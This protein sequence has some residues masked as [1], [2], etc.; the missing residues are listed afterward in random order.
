MPPYSSPR[1]MRREALPRTKRNSRSFGQSAR[2][3]RIPNPGALAKQC[4]RH[5]QVVAQVTTSEALGFL[6]QRATHSAPTAA[7]S[8]AR[9]SPSPLPSAPRRRSRGTRPRA[10]VRE[11][12][13][14]SP[15]CFG[16]PKPDVDQVGAAGDHLVETGQDLRVVL[17]AE[18]RGESAGDDEAGIDAPQERRP[19][20]GSV[21]GPPPITKSERPSRAATASNSTSPAPVSALERLSRRAWRPTP[22]ACR[23]RQPGRSP[24]SRLGSRSRPACEVDV[25][26]GG[27]DE[28]PWPVFQPLR[29]PLDNVVQCHC[30]ER[31]DARF[32][33][34]PRS[35][36]I[37]SCTEW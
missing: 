29:D 33:S 32:G 30:V 28:P 34:L 6:D 12:P 19:P 24:A 5:R 10:S 15:S 37:Q 21:R 13:S 27:D 18:P 25:D 35:T 16:N 4:E 20:V 8:P 14:P 11:V 9:D 1:S 23:Q 31:S 3:L 7:P 36:G 22:T 17:E 26:V 2:H